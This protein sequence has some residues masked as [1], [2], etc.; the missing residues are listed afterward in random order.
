MKLEN[1]LQNSHALSDILHNSNQC[2]NIHGLW[3]NPLEDYHT[4]YNSQKCCNFTC[5]KQNTHHEIFWPTSL[6]SV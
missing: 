3:S 4:Q 5:Y 2:H 6:T 1:T